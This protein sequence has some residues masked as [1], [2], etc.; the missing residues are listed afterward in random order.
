M[1]NQA[2]ATGSKNRASILTMSLLVTG[3]LLG[4]G[5]LALPV[6]L[7]P[8]GLLPALAGIVLVWALM[9]YSAY[10]LADQKELADGQAGGL[11][12][13]FGARLD[14]SA[15]WV[16]VAADMVIFYGVLTAYLTGTTAVVTGLFAVPAPKWVVTAAYFAVVAG[17][18]GF[19]MALLRRC[20]AAILVCMGLTFTALIVMVLP[21]AKASHALP[22]RWDFL[23]SAMPVALTAFL[24][25]NLVPTLCREMNGDKTAVRR[26]ILFGSLIGL[27]M[28]LAWTLAVFCALPM[29]GAQSIALLTAFEKNLPAT[30]PL[31]NLLGSTL[32]TNIGLVFAILSMSA[33]FLANG[34]ALLD[35]LRDLVRPA[36]GGAQGRAASRLAG[37]GAIWL[38]A[39]LPPLL[40]SVFYPDIFLVVMNLVGGVGICLLFGVLPAALRLQQAE[41]TARYAALAALTLFALILVC[42]VGQELGVMDIHPDVEY[43]S[44]FTE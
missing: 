15:K 25:H 16:A 18:T 27:A 33:A 22:M 17:L 12:A 29:E 42:E 34:T 20:N 43:W 7:G 14:P 39:F 36:P 21:E 32:F 24:F 10:V 23:P 2:S 19:G 9:L 31:S 41:G 5:I 35:F 38:V 30:V 1:T 11:P 37:D 40:V 28:N 8:A 26:A 13:F 4:A 44:Q 6:N 3:N